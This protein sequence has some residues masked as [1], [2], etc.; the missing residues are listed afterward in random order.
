[1][2]GVVVHSDRLTGNVVAF[3]LWNVLFSIQRMLVWIN[4]LLFF[5]TFPEWVE[6][7]ISVHLTQDNTFLS[8][9][10]G[11]G[12]KQDNYFWETA[13]N[14]CITRS[15]PQSMFESTHP[16][17]HPG[18]HPSTHPGSLSSCKVV[19]QSLIV[20]LLH[21]YVQLLPKWKCLILF[22]NQ[23]GGSQRERGIED[24]FY[25]LVHFWYACNSHV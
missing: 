13:R 25:S 1:M 5:H 16:S 10:W 15:I 14:Y 7:S 8:W 6:L 17:T 23:R 20:K 11:G 21:Y 19:T 24:W 12:S 18:T 3:E 9:T 2:F 4:C 22:E